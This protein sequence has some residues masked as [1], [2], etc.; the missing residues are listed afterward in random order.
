MAGL[1]AWRRSLHA[2]PD[3]SGAEGATAAAV[4]ERL[5]ATTPD[6]ILTGLGGHG[7]AAVYDGDEPGPTVMIRAELD[8]LPIE[9]TGRAAHRSVI[10]GHGHLCG[11]DGHMAILAGLGL[12]FGRQRPVRGRA[13]LLFQ[14]AEET[15]AGAAAVLADPRFAELRPDF[16]FALHNN[17]GSPL[18]AVELRTGPVN[19]ASRGLRIVL[20]GKTAHASQPETGVSPMAAVAA[21]M[22]A[23]TALGRGGA[24]D[25]SFSLVTVTHAAMGEPAFGIAPGRAEVWAT[26][27]TMVDDRMAAMVA[28]AEGLVRD[29]AA[30]TG[31][32]AR[33]DYHDVFA[34]CENHPEAVALLRAAL[35]AEG[36]SHR[37][38]RPFRASEDFG[39]FATV[40]RSAMFYLGAGEH[41]PALHNPDY[42]FPDALIPIGAAVFMRAAR[43]LL[44]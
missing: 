30:R 42:D 41:C 6:R 27:R 29:T 24:L 15:G 20:E 5:S 18:G 3:L 25:E 32:T 13:I 16:A 4:V 43:N 14:P 34:H 12:G 26:L 33:M 11:H 40:A 37:E 17:P 9:E 44:G 19:C 10:P 7:V 22:P 38:G 23:L 35:D 36:V 28:A 21:L 1:T 8:G 39:R 2:R 31:L